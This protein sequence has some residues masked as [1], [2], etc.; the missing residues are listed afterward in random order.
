MVCIICVVEASEKA[1]ANTQAKAAAKAQAKAAATPAETPAIVAPRSIKELAVFALEAEL[2]EKGIIED[3]KVYASEEQFFSD[4]SP[5]R[6]EPYLVKKVASVMNVVNCHVEVRGRISPFTT[7]FPKSKQGLRTGRSSAPIMANFP[8]IEREV[9]NTLYKFQP[10]H[11]THAPVLFDPA[12]KTARHVS[13]VSLFGLCA[14]C[15][16]CNGEYLNMGSIRYTINGDRVVFIVDFG[17]VWTQ[18]PGD[19][20]ANSKF[21]NAVANLTVEEW[22]Q[23]RKTDP[24]LIIKAATVCAGDVLGR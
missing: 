9:R 19:K 7:S 22:Q 20:I 1:K 13:T 23:L 16:W 10:T 24:S 15:F 5:P 18:L 11:H 2:K 14:S 12:H 4:K 6:S 8:A 3:M 17:K 21:F